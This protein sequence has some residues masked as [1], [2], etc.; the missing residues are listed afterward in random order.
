[1]LLLKEQTPFDESL[2]DKTLVDEIQRNMLTMRRQK[3]EELSQE[4]EA[5]NDYALHSLPLV[6]CL[7]DVADNLS[8]LLIVRAQRAE[9]CVEALD[10]I[11]SVREFHK[12]LTP[13]DFRSY[14]Q[15]GTRFFFLR[16]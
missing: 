13:P 5:A 11:C 8:S 3:R 4:G 2:I 10:Q 12:A 14:I 1:M 15:L 16:F 9:K 6:P 7:Q